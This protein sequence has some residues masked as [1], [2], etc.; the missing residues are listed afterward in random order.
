[1]HHNVRNTR[2]RTTCAKKLGTAGAVPASACSSQVP[3]PDA[4]K[5]ILQGTLARKLMLLTA[6]PF[7]NVVR[8]IPPLVTSREEVDQA[9]AILDEV[10][11]EV[12]SAQV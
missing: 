1:M 3:N 4:A 6:S 2:T 12:T 8:I 7:G 10:L 5:R 11:A 9:L